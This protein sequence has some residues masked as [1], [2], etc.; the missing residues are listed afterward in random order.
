MRYH[1]WRRV[2]VAVV[3]TGS[4]LSFSITS[5]VQLTR[6]GSLAGF[7]DNSKSLLGIAAGLGLA[8]HFR[9]PVRTRSLFLWSAH[10]SVTFW[11][12]RPNDACQMGSL[13]P[14]VADKVMVS[15]GVI[16][17]IC[18][19]IYG[20]IYQKVSVDLSQGR[21]LGLVASGPLGCHGNHCAPS[22]ATA[23]SME[24]AEG[25]CWHDRMVLA[26]FLPQVPGLARVHSTRAQPLL[27]ILDLGGY[28]LW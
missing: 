17:A 14:F 9:V 18:S 8:R 28:A 13:E 16:G 24:K 27:P 7:L 5:L 21:R 19:W 12:N 6:M 25:N 22:L 1:L 11:K 15:N 2:K 23:V 10:R 4:L 3:Q 26:A 20:R